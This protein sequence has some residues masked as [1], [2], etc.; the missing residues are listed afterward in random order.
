MV[1]EFMNMP[2]L[3]YQESKVQ[4]L[5]SNCKI[6]SMKKINVLSFYTFH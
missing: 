1:S 2:V 4:C 6:V 3:I 5:I